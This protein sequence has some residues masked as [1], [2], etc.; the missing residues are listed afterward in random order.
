MIEFNFKNDKERKRFLKEYDKW[1][2]WFVEPHTNITYYRCQLPT[3][4]FI[5]VEKQPDVV[6]KY[7]AY[8]TMEFIVKRERYHLYNDVFDMLETNETQILGVLH[9]MRGTYDIKV[10]EDLNDES[11][12]GDA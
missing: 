10:A 12:D 8:G 7:G 9:G 6:K 5:V 3:K 2:I 11:G 1:G 4:E